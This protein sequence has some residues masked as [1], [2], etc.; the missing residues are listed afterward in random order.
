M[1]YRKASLAQLYYISRYT[2]YAPEAKKE[3]A[4]RLGDE[5]IC[6]PSSKKA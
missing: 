6:N 2:E 5:T 1:D 3:L 4:R